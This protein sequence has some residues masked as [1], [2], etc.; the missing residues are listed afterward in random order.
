[1]LR[2]KL[3]IGVRGVGVACLLPLAILGKLCDARTRFR[4]KLAV[5]VP[6]EKLP[7]A[8]HSVRG[9]RGPPILL[10]ATASSEQSH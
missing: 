3:L 4:R 1:M 9:L 10:F 5:R 7:V 8:L 6:L 2:E